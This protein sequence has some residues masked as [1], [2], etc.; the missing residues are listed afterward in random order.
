M[1]S[2][3]KQP[4]DAPGQP[5]GSDR[6]RKTHLRLGRAASPGAAGGWDP[7]PG[8]G[9]ADKKGSPVTEEEEA[10]LW[11]RNDPPAPVPPPETPED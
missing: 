1:P 2:R 7:F 3:G 8:N 5:P 11:G 9:S 4:P 10:I 6:K